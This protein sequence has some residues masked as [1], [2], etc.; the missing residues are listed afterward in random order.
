MVYFL[1][2]TISKANIW[3]YMMLNTMENINFT[4]TATFMNQSFDSG[5]E[6][7]TLSQSLDTATY[8]IYTEIEHAI[9]N[10]AIKR[11]QLVLPLYV[12]Q[13]EVY[14]PVYRALE[15]HCQQQLLSIWHEKM[16]KTPLLESDLACL[17]TEMLNAKVQRLTM[18]FMQFVDQT[19]KQNHLKLLGILYALE[20]LSLLHWELSPHIHTMY[21]LKTKG[22]AFYRSYG[23]NV[24]QHWR[25][26]TQSIDQMGFNVFEQSEV[27]AGA[28]QTFER[29]DKLLCNLWK[30]NRLYD[31]A[32][33]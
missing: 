3:V 22:G 21:A 14:L 20:K 8:S 23:S 9:F 24:Y 28:T 10:Q 5:I 11:E 6:K 2:I 1:L 31:K 25:A 26:F 17:Q 16:M 7:A 13:L 15:R 18:D 19:G 29:I 27:M 33:A 4:D 32:A 30:L 12:N